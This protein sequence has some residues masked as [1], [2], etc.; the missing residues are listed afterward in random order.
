MKFIIKFVQV[1]CFSG[2]RNKPKYVVDFNKEDNEMIWTD[3]IK[4]AKHYNSLRVAKEVGSQ[5]PVDLHS[6]PEF[7]EVSERYI[8][9][10][11]IGIWAILD[12]KHPEFH[13]RSP[14][15]HSDNPWVVAHWMGHKDTND[16]WE[17]STDDTEQAKRLLE[18]LN[19]NE[20]VKSLANQALARIYKAVGNFNPKYPMGEGYAAEFRLAMEQ[21]GETLETL[22]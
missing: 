21:V 3:D 22:D 15:C 11:R 1:C 9:D 16:E 14:G 18:T 10:Q 20:I 12:T 6:K 19:G 5:I 13:K 17:M 7:L 2:H 4:K 8:L